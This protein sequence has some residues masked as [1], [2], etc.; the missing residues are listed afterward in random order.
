MDAKSS[1]SGIWE[2]TFSCISV[3]KLWMWQGGEAL[4]PMQEAPKSV[5]KMEEKKGALEVAVIGGP[6]IRL[7]KCP[8]LPCC[9]GHMRRC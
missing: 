9:V 5:I 6:Q 8:S 2:Y 7:I 4:L 3:T 1:G